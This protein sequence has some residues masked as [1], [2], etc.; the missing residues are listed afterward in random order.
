MERVLFISQRLSAIL[1]APFVLI[2]LGMILYAVRGGLT[3]A[4]ILGRTQGSVFWGGFYILFVL[5]VSIHAPIGIRNI[6]R[7]WTS[8]NTSRANVV[9]ILFGLLILIL[10]L[11]SVSAIYRF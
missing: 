5:A 3:G 11:R 1:L 10:G 9:A 6:L 8:L 4:E 2:H 7:E